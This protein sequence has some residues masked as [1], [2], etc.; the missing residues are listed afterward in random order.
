MRSTRSA[1]NA[2]AALLAGLLV[3][4]CGDSAEQP[5]ET[6]A[7]VPSAPARTLYVQAPLTGPAAAEGRAMV[8]AVRL[9]VQQGDGLAGPSRLTV[10]ALDD[11]G[12][13]TPTD[14]ER[15]AA[16]AARAAS[17]AR[18]LAVIGTYE[19]ACSERALRVL[20]PAGLLLV[21][22][23]NAAENLPGALRLAPTLADQG[24]AAAQLAK[25]LEAT[26]V[27]IVSRRPGAGA[28]FATGLA[29]AAP[30][31]GL[32]A[33]A[34]LDASSASAADLADD[35]VAARVE[36]VALAGSPGPWAAGLL[37]ALALEPE[38]L[39]PDVV[40][41]QS[42]HSLAFL[43][44][45]GPAAEGVH[46]LSRLVPVEELG[47]GATDFAEAYAE[48][49]GQPQPVAVY[50]A[51]AAEAVLE[52]AATASGA[53]ASMAAA[54]LALPDHDSLIG[55]WAATPSGGVTPRRIAVLDVAGGAFRDERMLTVAGGLPFSGEVK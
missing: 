50:A 10:H 45:A 6:T 32:E 30:A 15:C 49:H 17:D 38:A 55:R 51:A 43:D 25:A 41:P 28:A 48:L 14:P 36:V 22:P 8:A 39:R 20:R 29:L 52:A 53:R 3:A 12:D 7:A 42:F 40:V 13:E 26:R 23:L 46:V 54:L 37:R 2:L 16:N 35:L 21:S 4:G 18:A 19:L 31:A 34:Q 44:E 24:T 1:A 9:I 11:G 47:G 33:V 27:A 5:P